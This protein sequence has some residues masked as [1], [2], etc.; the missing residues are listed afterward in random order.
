M[1]RLIKMGE[2][3]GEPENEFE[4]MLVRT[5]LGVIL[6]VLAAIGMIAGW[7]YCGINHCG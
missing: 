4:A 1:G 5:G 2:L 7:A 6:I 3:M